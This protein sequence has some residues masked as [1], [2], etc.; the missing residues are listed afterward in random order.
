MQGGVVAHPREADARSCG[1]YTVTRPDNVGCRGRE[2]AARYPQYR[3]GEAPARNLKSSSAINSEYCPSGSLH[4]RKG[5]GTHGGRV[6]DGVQTVLGTDVQLRTTH[7][8]HR[9]GRKTHTRRTQGNSRKTVTRCTQGLS[10]AP[11]NSSTVRDMLQRISAPPRAPHRAVEA[12]RRGAHNHS[13]SGVPA[14]ERGPS[15]THEN[16]RARAAAH[17]MPVEA[18]GEGYGMRGGGSPPDHAAVSRVQAVHTAISRA[19]VHLHRVSLWGAQQT[20]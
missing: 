9:K 15:F 13:A 2:G 11:S 16:S 20:A 18:L 14:Y 10:T 12:D 17:S 6:S 19:N 5:R 1:K 3:R 8:I 7:D 4:G